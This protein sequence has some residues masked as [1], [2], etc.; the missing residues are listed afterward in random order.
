MAGAA[1][2]GGEDADIVDDRRDAAGH[3]LESLLRALPA[4]P[5]HVLAGHQPNVH[6]RKRPT[7]RA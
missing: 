7:E 6:L 1:Y 3:V 4:R 2:G 5:L